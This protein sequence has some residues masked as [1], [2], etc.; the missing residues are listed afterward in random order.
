MTDSACVPPTADPSATSVSINVGDSI[1]QHTHDRIVNT[2][3]GIIDE[4]SK[5]VDCLKEVL[6]CKCNESTMCESKLCT[7]EFHLEKSYNKIR[8]GG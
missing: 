4:L 2:K 3:D 7:V 1:K 8:A 6:I 5:K